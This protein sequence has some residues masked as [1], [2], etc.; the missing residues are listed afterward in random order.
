MAF[1]IF[2][3]VRLF[4]REKAAHRASDD[5][6]LIGVLLSDAASRVLNARRTIVQ[7]VV[8]TRGVLVQDYTAALISNNS[9][10]PDKGLHLPNLAVDLRRNDQDGPVPPRTDQRRI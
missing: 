8:H 7:E 10:I 6:R 2:P 3:S 1:G 9:S 5:A 4:V